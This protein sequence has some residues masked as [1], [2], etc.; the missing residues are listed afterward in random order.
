MNIDDPPRRKPSSFTSSTIPPLV[1]SLKPVQLPTSS[2]IEK[3]DSTSIT[4][5]RDISKLSLSLNRKVTPKLEEASPVLV[6]KP[7]KNITSSLNETLGVRSVDSTL[8][9]SLSL[10]KSPIKTRK[11]EP[12]CPLCN[13]SYDQISRRP[14][15][16]NSCG[17]TMC[18]QCFIF[19][20]N[21]NGCVQCETVSNENIPTKKKP[22]DDDFD[23]FD[24]DQLFDEWRESESMLR[25]SSKITEQDLINS[26]YDEETEVEDNA[27]DDRDIDEDEEVT[28]LYNND[29]DEEDDYN[30]N[31]DDE[32]DDDEQNQS[33]LQIRPY[34]VQWLADV[35][36]D[37]AEFSSDHSYPHTKSMLEIFSNVFGLKQ[38]LMNYSIY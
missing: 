9:G 4:P 13:Q 10:K 32:D 31:D 2:S 22:A 35:K 15:S 5:V 38:V 17:H 18:L 1:S 11:S 36:N 14:I 27:D 26:I 7:P 3:N 23:D 29:N 25:N 24:Q 37:A 6:R 33:N 28:D 34:Q 19:N 16:E 8:N 30:N 12:S 21:Q 20:N